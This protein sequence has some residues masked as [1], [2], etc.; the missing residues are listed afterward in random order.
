MTLLNPR[1]SQLEFTADIGVS[2]SLIFS[3]TVTDGGGLSDTDVVT[4]HILKAEAYFHSADY[5]P[6]DHK[7][8]LSELLRVIQLYNNVSYRCDPDEKDG[9]AIGEGDRECIPHDA[10]YSPL[11][12]RISLSELLRMIQLY[13]APEYSGDTAGEDGFGTRD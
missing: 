8:G 12:W 1:S 13:N 6:Q 11:D 5:N 10:D 7:L 3:L 9:Y 4:V 2:E